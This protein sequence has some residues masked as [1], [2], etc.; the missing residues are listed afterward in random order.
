MAFQGLPSE[1]LL[2]LRQV[3]QILQITPRGVRD[4]VARNKLPKPMR[5]GRLLRWTPA[6]LDQWISHQ[7]VTPQ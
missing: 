2:T 3:A 5:V 7:Q 1:Q 6:A 4:L